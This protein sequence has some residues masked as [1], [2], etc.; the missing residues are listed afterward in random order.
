MEVYSIV[1]KS[2]K[3]R[4]TTEVQSF[5][6]FCRL[7]VLDLGSSGPLLPTMISVLSKIKGRWFMELKVRRWSAGSSH[8][9]KGGVA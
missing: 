2:V 5:W 7:F 4:N 8:L 3:D 1:Q 6:D 9:D